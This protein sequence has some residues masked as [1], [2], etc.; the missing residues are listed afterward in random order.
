MI[1]FAWL[2]FRLFALVIAAVWLSNHPGKVV[3]NWQGYL[4]ETSVGALI[5]L[6]VG[7]L[8]LIV[9]LSK[10]FRDLLRLPQRWARH[11]QAQTDR[12]GRKALTGGL[13]AVASGDAEAARR[14][15]RQTEASIV[16]PVLSH[17][18]TAEALIL[19]GENDAA[20][21]QF[22]LLL[23]REDTRV[24]GHRGLIEVALARG[25]WARAYSRA[26][27]ARATMAK[28]PWLATLLVDLAARAGDLEEARITLDH[29]VR[30]RLITGAEAQRRQT[31]LWTA[32]AL[33]L[34]KDGN[35]AQALVLAEK[36]L[37]EDPG[38]VP[39]AVVAARLNCRD[40]RSKTA[41][42]LLQRAWALETHPELVQAWRGI[43]E[44]GD[45]PALALWMKRLAE[46]RNGHPGAALAYA[47]AAI[48]ARLWAE[49]RR[50]LEPV[51][52][53]LPTAEAGRA[54]LLLGRLEREETGNLTAAVA[55]YE[56][57]S[58]GC[59]P[60]SHWT[61]H[62]CGHPPLSWSEICPACGAFAEIQSPERERRAQPARAAHASLPGIGTPLSAATP[63]AVNDATPHSPAARTS[64]AP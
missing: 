24:I 35:A 10:V 2:G 49:A 25:D 56:R 13:A 5:V 44:G 48:D 64:A 16:D 43:A 55:W 18:L 4:V 19:S 46:A 3:I 29:A 12:R 34:E 27:Q 28:S 39:A 41:E 7:S 45:A 52:A 36:A 58:T 21:S 62:A 32:Q 11:R 53:T 23:G 63:R 9:L 31:A 51:A 8:L 20:E 47:E 1:R 6:T 50:V 17:L 22:E 15:S 33:R 59:V 60:G 37:G 57:A 42:R 30:T 38:F 40:D 61:C 26:R 14:L 54:C